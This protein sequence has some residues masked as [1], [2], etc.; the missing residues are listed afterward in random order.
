MLKNNKLLTSALSTGRLYLQA[1]LMDK[2]ER[3]DSIA[4]I[5]DARNV[6]LRCALTYHFNVDVPFCKSCEH[7]PCNTDKIAHLLSYKGED[8][9]VRMHRDLVFM[10]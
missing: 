4:I 2:V 3:F 8:S 6:D 5:N 9:H 1:A 7:A 10:N